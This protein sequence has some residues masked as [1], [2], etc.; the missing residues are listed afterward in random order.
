MLSKYRFIGERI[1]KERMKYNLSLSELAREIGVS[2][3]L[4]S[5]V[6]NGK[7]TASMKV[8]DKIC[9]FFSIH[10]ASLFE[11]D[12]ESSKVILLKSDKQLEVKIDD[13]RIRR[14]LL[15]RTGVPVEPVLVIIEPE[16]ASID[17]SVHKGVEY[18]Y[19][20]EGKIIVEVEG[21]EPVVCCK[22]DSVFYKASQ[23]HRLLNSFLEKAVGLWIAVPD[24]NS[25]AG[26]TSFSEEGKSA[27]R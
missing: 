15:P 8:L 17:F 5:L 16:A 18:G 25:T 26:H 4:L 12:K 22:G 20:L 1:R 7:A 11:E 3:S 27:R 9:S 19:V 13:Y 6:E 14:F 24:V 23:P 21:D 2:V 10:M